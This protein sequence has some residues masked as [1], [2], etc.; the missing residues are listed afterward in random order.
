MTFKTSWD[1]WTTDCGPRS[2][3]LEARN[4]DVY[5]VVHHAVTRRVQDIIALSKPGGRQVSMSFAIGPT[6]AGVT[7]PV[8]CVGIVPEHM[9]PYTTAAPIDHAALTVEVANIDLTTTYPVAE[10]A[11]EWIAKIAAYMHH[12]YGMPLDRVH[13]LSHQEVYARGLGS[14]PTACPGPD[15]QASLDQIV[16]RAKVLATPKGRKRGMT[17]RYAMIGSGDGKGGPGTICAL[18]GDVG[19]P[20]P[21][22]FD[23]Y[24]RGTVQGHDRAVEEFAVHGPPIWVTKDEWPKLRARYTTA[25][26]AGKI[27]VDNSDI[28]RALDELPAAIEGARGKKV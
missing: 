9:R 1:D 2:S 22:N 24:V 7:S 21:G 26:T 15:L 23:E 16:A 25:P 3:P 11:K 4:G 5:L 17:T 10:D 14:Y 8:Y 13:I 20:C 27:V 18:A 12:T 28:I 19:Y 6:V